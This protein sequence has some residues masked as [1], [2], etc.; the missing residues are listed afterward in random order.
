MKLRP[1]ESK[2][3][4]KGEEEEKVFPGPKRMTRMFFGLCLGYGGIKM[5]ALIF[6]IPKLFLFLSKL[7]PHLHF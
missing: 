4:S 2:P 7:D 3:L 6:H 1:I 5:S